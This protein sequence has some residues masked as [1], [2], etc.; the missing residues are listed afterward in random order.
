MEVRGN[1]KLAGWCFG[2]GAAQFMILLMLCESIAPGYS[3]H[4]NA[5]SD[6]GTIAETRGIF[7]F[8][9]VL[10]GICIIV[11]SYIVSDIWSD[12]T[13]LAIA[14]V[15]S[16]GVIGAG[17]VA[18]DNPIGL[19]GLFALLAF[20]LLNIWAILVGI[21]HF[22]CQMRLVSVIAG[23]IGVIFL[24]LMVLGDSGGDFG[25]IGHGGTERMIAFPVLLW[26]ILA[27]G[28]LVSQANASQ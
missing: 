27:G 9:M 25:A 17:I 1:L 22:K 2:L 16:I 24:V 10:L 14:V 8:T 28:Y 21:R 12:R 19:H 4:D 26:F 3:M 18:L 6:L 23:G 11:G 20:L 15:G 7:T 5:I 13:S